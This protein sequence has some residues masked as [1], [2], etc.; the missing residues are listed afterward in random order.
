MTENQ[1]NLRPKTG[2]SF[3]ADLDALDVV[4]SLSWSS[5]LFV[6]RTPTVQPLLYIATATMSRVPSTE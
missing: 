5:S 4:A 1:E 2:K 6:S 3:R